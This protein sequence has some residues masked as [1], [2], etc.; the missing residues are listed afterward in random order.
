M[1][2]VGERGGGGDIRITNQRRERLAAWLLRIVRWLPLPLIIGGALFYLFTPAGYTSLPFFEAAPLIVAP[3]YSLRGTIAIG[4]L[5]LAV[6]IGL[7]LYNGTADEPTS[8]VEMFTELL[9]VCTAVV[10]NRLI[11][12]HNRRLATARGVAE[13]AQRAV[14]PHPPEMLGGLQV[15]ARYVPADADALIGGD[16]YVAQETQYGVRV[17]VGDVR[18]KGL[19]AVHAVA[20]SVG[21]FREAAEDEPCLE[22][23]ANRLDRAVRRGA[24]RRQGLAP[25]EGF[26]TAV[27]AEFDP[28]AGVVRILSRGHP[29]PLLLTPDGQV[30]PVAPEE[31]SLPLGMGDLGDWPD[32]IAVAHFP[33]GASLLF[34]TDGV[35]EARDADGVFYDPEVAL[36]DRAFAGPA[37]LL[38]A[39]EA[40]VSAHIGGRQQD[41]M[42][43]L[44]LT[45]P[46]AAAGV[47]QVP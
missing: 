32:E 30:R 15:A 24:Q 17:V 11:A 39:L 12:W 8:I 21:V 19:G 9:V 2:Q 45:R 36:R 43:L 31:A 18:G 35:T 26:I 44:A 1:M 20:V 42:A 28:E 34:F 27:F 38:A 22:S 29:A 40:D 33:P 37:G 14:L 7:E 41:D 47:R 10:M 6:Q 13:A 46:R 3:V 23:L 25:L 4:V 16:M 5:A